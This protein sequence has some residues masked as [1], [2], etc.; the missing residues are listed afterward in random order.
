VSA[1]GVI[2]K[3][4]DVGAT[5]RQQSQDLI[6]A[7]NRAAARVQDASESFAERLTLVQA[8]S[9][10]AAQKLQGFADQFKEQATTVMAAGDAAVARN[11]QVGDAI[12]RHT[13]DLAG[14]TD[15]AT[16]RLT[17]IR[18]SLKEQASELN[19]TTDKIAAKVKEVGDAY[20]RQSAE[21]VTAAD[22]VTAKAKDTIHSLD[23]Q[24]QALTKASN[25]AANQVS[26]IRDIVVETQQDNFL[27]SATFIIEQLQS[28]AVDINRVIDTDI[29]DGVWK[30]FHAGD[31]A[32]FTRQLLQTQDRTT[33]AA[34]KRKFEEDGPFRD[35]VLRYLGQFETL[36][37][38]AK[39]ID[40]LNVL[41][42]TFVTADVGKLYV[43]L[44]N[45]IGRLKS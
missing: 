45:A 11:G 16:A 31:R 4:R 43:I 5:L 36:L 25:D 1:D 41:S 12:R 19:A 33:G 26:L 35:A 20:R 2:G 29:P 10:D 44:S 39:T 15:H 40:H 30:R 7:S 27:K 42:A 24:A 8:G 22:R 18:D 28:I 9:D 14:A 17:E 34:I 6:E 3:V 32:I 21:L 13:R 37:T 23:S 38:Q